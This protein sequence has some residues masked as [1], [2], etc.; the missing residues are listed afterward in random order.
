MGH[1]GKVHMYRGLCRSGCGVTGKK[2]IL[3]L[4]SGFIKLS[5]VEIISIMSSKHEA[6]TLHCVH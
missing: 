3:Y 4:L 6:V 5:Q 1:G 2:G